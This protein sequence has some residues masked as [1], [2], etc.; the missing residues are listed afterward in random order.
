MKTVGTITKGI[1]STIGRII[2]FSVLLV[3]AVIASLII[4]AN[5]EGIA[6]GG[7]LII[8]W[9]LFTLSNRSKKPKKEKETEEE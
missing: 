1:F 8:T 7:G 3:I 5:A 2:K 4:I 6:E 9:V